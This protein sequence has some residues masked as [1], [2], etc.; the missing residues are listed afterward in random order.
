M[1]NGQK[2]CGVLIEFEDDYFLIGIGCN[3]MTA[4]T[5][6]AIGAEGGRPATCLAEHN[7]EIKSYLD[8]E[9]TSGGISENLMTSNTPNIPLPL[10][11]ETSDFHKMVAID[12]FKKF[13]SWIEEANDTN[14]LIIQDFSRN[15]DYSI[16]KLRDISDD[17]TNKV[18]PLQL[19]EDGTL[20]VNFTLITYFTVSI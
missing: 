5:I 9:I 3:V 19:N 15:M 20:L 8:L 11:L 1:I 18:E 7:Y 14:S 12:L 10:K 13:E 17:N 16:Q 4:P 2:T 6:Q